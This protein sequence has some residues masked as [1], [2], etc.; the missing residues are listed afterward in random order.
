[1]ARRWNIIHAIALI[2]R[3]IRTVFVV[4]PSASGFPSLRH[5]RFRD[6]SEVM[7]ETNP[8]PMVHVQPSGLID[9]MLARIC[10][11]VEFQ[12]VPQEWQS[13]AILA[14]ARAWRRSLAWQ[15]NM[16][17]MGIQTPRHPEHTSWTA[18]SVLCFPE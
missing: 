9:R 2:S 17:Y 5:A 1:M 3:P 15:S 8:V 6:G 14:P 4:T 13:L 7:H 10:P 18:E 16:S 12:R 11:V